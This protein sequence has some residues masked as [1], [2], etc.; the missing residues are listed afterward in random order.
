MGVKYIID[1]LDNSLTEQIINGSVSATTFSATTYYGDGSNLTGLSTG[2]NVG[3][4]QL[5]SG[6][7]TR[8]LFQSGTTLQ[9]DSNFTYNTTQKRLTLRA[10]GTAATDIPFAVQNSGGSSNLMQVAGDNTM[11]FLS[12][13]NI[14]FSSS[15]AGGNIKIKR[16]FSSQ[17]MIELGGGDNAFISVTPINLSSYIAIGSS[18]NGASINWDGTNF[19]FQ[20]KNSF[21]NLFDVVGN[22]NSA[23]A[24]F[25]IGTI[26]SNT[27]FF[28]VHGRN[29]GGTALTTNPV[30]T[31]NSSGTVGI[32]T[33]ASTPGARL[34]VRAQG[35]L[36]TDIVFRVR[37]SGDS[38]NIVNF[39]GNGQFTIGLGASVNST[40][41]PEYS[42]VI[43]HNASD[44]VA[45]NR[46][47]SV[48]IG[49]LASGNYYGV[50]IG[51]QSTSSGDAG[52]AIGA[53]A[54]AGANGSALGYQATAAGAGVS[55]GKLATSTSQGAI[56]IGT[57]TINN[58]NYSIVFN[59]SLQV[60][61]N[62]HSNVCK[63]YFNSTKQSFF[64]HENGRFVINSKVDLVANTNYDNSATNTITIT[65]GTT[66]TLNIVDSFQLYSADITAGNAAPHFRTE[67]G[68]IVKLYQETTGV[69]TSTLISNVGTTITDTDT[70]DGY[71]LQQVVKALRNLGILQ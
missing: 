2:L 46:T 54:T 30:F 5:T 28:N 70:F 38:N 26:A 15:D 19:R 40:T 56:T 39:N 51:T 33:E 3:T 55:I 71:T 11:T 57:N 41:L 10:V 25:R 13:G 12:L 60:I 29:A 50:A 9:Q 48:A 14:G 65:T 49:R 59:S 47:A 18:A 36:S 24:T 53:S 6:T 62:E 58:Q 67:N 20:I 22:P 69:T 1:N 27:N 23:T 4:S 52:V 16:N 8:V 43:G 42:V 63:M 66:P 31:I 68:S 35:V 34:D 32:G 37:N 64:Y 21:H 61:T 44:G 7:N 45:G 17:T